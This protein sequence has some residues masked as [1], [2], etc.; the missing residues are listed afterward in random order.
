MFGKWMFSR[1]G[2]NYGTQS[3][4]WSLGPVEFPH[5]S[6]PIVF[7]DI[8]GDS[9]IPE[10]ALYLNY[11]RHLGVRSKFL[12]ESSGTC[13]F[14]AQNN[15]HAKE[16]FWGGTF[17]SPTFCLLEYRICKPTL[18][19]I[20]PC[21]CLILYH[22]KA[23][24]KKN[25]K[26]CVCVCVCV[27]VCSISLY[28]VVC[29]YIHTHTYTYTYSNVYVCMCMKDIAVHLKLTQ[30]CKSTTLQEKERQKK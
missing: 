6:Y 16:I 13:L 1:P 11:C 30:Q 20:L 29:I 23:P 8:S 26:K 24:A 22:I 9:P 7:A 27:C 12:P 21:F 4:S 10:K 5:H 18:G 19:S 15:S 14:S 28:A 17:C 2:R 3:G 25:L